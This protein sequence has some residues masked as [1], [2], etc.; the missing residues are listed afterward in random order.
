MLTEA[1]KTTIRNEDIA[2][3]LI[4]RDDYFELSAEQLSSFYEW[5]GTN[6]TNYYDGHTDDG[7]WVADFNVG[8]MFDAWVQQVSKHVIQ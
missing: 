5:V 6:W 2:D 3:R 7:E 1:E 8:A 4:A